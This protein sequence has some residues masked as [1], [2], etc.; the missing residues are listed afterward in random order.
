MFSYLVKTPSYYEAC[1]YQQKPKKSQYPK[2]MSQILVTLT[3]RTILTLFFL[4]L[5]LFLSR[6]GHSEEFAVPNSGSPYKNLADLET[7]QILHL[8]TGLVVS[9]KQMLDSII[10]S[11][12]IYI[13]ETHDNIE[14]HK[15]QLKIIKLLAEKYT[16]TIGLEMFRRS[17][18]KKLNLWNQGQLTH[19]EFKNLFR[20]NWGS[21]FSLYQPIFEFAKTRGLSLIGLK[22]SRE[23]ENHFRAGDPA[24]GN[25]LYPEIDYNDLYHRNFSMSAF[26]GHTVKALEKPYRM[27][28]LWEETM[29][30]TVAEFLSNPINK[31]KKLVVLAGGFHVQY[32]FGIPKRAYRRI[33]HN[34]SIILPNVTKIPEN[35]KGREM[36]VKKVSIPLYASDYAWKVEYIVP[37][38]SKIKLGV[39]LN[40]EKDDEIRIKSVGDNSNAQIAGMK[41]GDLLIKM[42]GNT[43]SRVDDLL[44]LL[45]NKKLNDRSTFELKRNNKILTVL[46]VFKEAKQ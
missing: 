28:L 31:D 44:E 11:R 17:A 41:P 46:V 34:Y 5:L 32:G 20:S 38:H 24:P 6:N 22:S 35:L 7:G 14:A 30:Q 40:Q 18:K 10:S 9:A 12:V 43:L 29:A 15:V 25:T 39:G 16:V 36:K 45:E 2:I 42:D 33:P 23:V 4:L 3:I 27:L 1:D 21:G 8:P 19:K 37:G 13:G 26:G